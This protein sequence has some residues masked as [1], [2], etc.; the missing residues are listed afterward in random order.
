MYTRRICITL[1]AFL[2]YKHGP[3]EEGICTPDAYQ[4]ELSGWWNCTASYAVPG[5]K[6][7][8]FLTDGQDVY[9][10][11]HSGPDGEFELAGFYKN[12]TVCVFDKHVGKGL[13]TEL[14]IFTS[15]L[16][17]GSPFK[18]ADGTHAFSEAGWRA[19]QRAF[20]EANARGL[21]SKQTV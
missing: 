7:Y 13:G 3:S 9:I 5:F 20:K 21:L 15:L 8:E 14:I 18:H 6:S 2:G 12:F 19:H 16:R 11:Y 1:D 4:D 10:K 17:E